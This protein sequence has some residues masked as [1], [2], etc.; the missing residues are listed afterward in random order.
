MIALA[1]RLHDRRGLDSRRHAVAAT[2][3]LVRLLLAPLCAACGDVLDRPLAGP[4]CRGVLARVPALTPPCCVRCGDA[5]PLARGAR[6]AR[7]A[8]AARPPFTLARSAGRYDGSLRRD[9]PRLQ[10]RRP[11]GARRAARRADARGRRRRA[12]PA[13]TPSCRCRFIPGA[14]AARLQSGRR[15]RPYLG[16]PV[17]R[18]LR[19]RRTARPGHPP[20][21]AAPRQRAR[22]LR[23]SRSLVVAAP[24]GPARSPPQPRRRPRRRRDDDGRDDGS[25]CRVLTDGGRQER[26]RADGRASRGSTACIHRLRHV[27]LRMLGVDDDPARCAA[28]RR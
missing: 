16:L 7:A 26:A 8:A 4:V 14:P 11:T 3:A 13:P 17:W 27:I 18:V 5:L 15:P 21:G 23:A 9:H 28:W 2:N 6:S 22:R 25:V 20:G 19:R 12:A 1:A 10:V 24:V